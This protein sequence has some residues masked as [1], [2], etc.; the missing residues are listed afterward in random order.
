MTVMAAPLLT[1]PVI[2]TERL[3]LRAPREGDHAAMAAFYAS[4]RSR[5]VGGPCD[6]FQAWGRLLGGLGHWALRGYGWW[7]LESRATGDMVGRLGVGFSLG[8]DEPELG[9]HIYDGYEG[10]GLALDGALAA[11]HHATTVWGMGPL[12]SYIVPE[13]T[14]SRALAER[15]GAR[16]ERDGTVVGHPCLVY[17][18]PQT[19][20]SA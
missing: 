2:E 18:H 10:K 8:W 1:V 20:V 14:R 17:R 11:R 9:W 6:P 16:V 15:M 7:T 19:G 5:F 13:N 3:I 12:I 4:E